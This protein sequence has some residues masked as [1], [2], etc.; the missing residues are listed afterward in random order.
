MV[1]RLRAARCCAHSGFGRGVVVANKWRYLHVLQGYYG[2]RWEDICQSEN[3]AEMIV[4]RRTYIENAPQYRYR[5][6]RRREAVS[7]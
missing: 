1:G 3:R 2:F 5:I 6:V 7:E 4:D